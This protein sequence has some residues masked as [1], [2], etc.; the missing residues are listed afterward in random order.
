MYKGS[1]TQLQ[2]FPKQLRLLLVCL[3]RKDAVKT[4]L[5][6]SQVLRS[7]AVGS[8]TVYAVLRSVAKVNASNRQSG[9]ELTFHIIR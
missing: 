6:F 4:G 3:Q 9:S 7:G 8:I 1:S 5:I 2:L